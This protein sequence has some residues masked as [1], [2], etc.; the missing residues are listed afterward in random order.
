[1]SRSVITSLLVV[2]TLVL[3]TAS[4]ALANTGDSRVL[5]RIQDTGVIHIGYATSAVP[6]SYMDPGGKPIGYSINICMRIVDAIRNKLNNQA[7]NVRFIPVT[8]QTRFSYMANGQIDMECGATTN[9][10][11]RQTMVS[12][13]P[14]T[15][16]TGTRILARKDSGAKSVEDLS[17]KKLGVATQT[18]N[19]KALKAYIQANKLDIQLVEVENS[20]EG[21]RALE[22]KRI[23][24]FSSDDVLLHGVKAKA[25]NPD[26]YAI[27]G[28]FLSFDSYGIL[29]PRND[30]T[31]EQLGTSVLAKLM[32]S[33]QLH[34]LYAKWFEPGPTNINIPLSK[35]LNLIFQVQGLPD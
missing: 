7:I 23:D 17:G 32:R 5:K 33:G 11:T 6:F 22:A 28:N 2:A 9:N 34:E 25:K 12:F 15:F 1:M 14:T 35:T 19:E 21:L 18:T 10:L 29:V 3:S 20:I 24:A 30:S 4:A 16:I 13:L 8:D 26:D 31:F 27:I